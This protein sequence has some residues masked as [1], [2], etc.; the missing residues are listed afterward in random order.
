MVSGYSS[1]QTPVVWSVET[2][3][4]TS[5]E[6]AARLTAEG[7]GDADDDEA[8]D[9]GELPPPPDGGY[10]WVVVFASFMCNLVVD[11]IAYTFG[12]F[13]PE[14]V[15]YFGEGKGTVAW[16]GSLLSGVYLAAGPVVSALCNKYGCRAVCVAGSLI[17]TVAFALSTLSKSVTMMMLTY[18]LI[19][20]IGF[21]MIYLPSVVAVGYYF[22]T[23]RS[24]A[25]GIAVC[26]SGV[27][28]FS[29]APLA[30][31]LLKEFGSWQNANL[32]L[33]GLILNCAVFG[34]LMRPLVYPKTSGE[35]PLLQ[36]MAEEKR[37]QMERG[38]IGGSYFVVQLPDG[39]MEKRLKAPLNI[40]PGVHSSLNLEALARVP[41]V[42]NMPGVPPV[43]T[44]PTITEAKV[45]DDNGE[46]KKAENGS[47]V[48]VQPMSRNVSSPAFSAQAPGL[49][50]NGS[51]P[52]FD[53]QR[54]HSTGE[55]FKPSLAAIKAT[56][57]TS[58]N[59]QHRNAPD[60]D[61]ESGMYNSKLSVSAAREPS[62][63]VRPMSRKDIFYSGSVLNLPQY[64]SQKSLQGY[65]NSVLSLPQSRQAGDLDR[66]EQYDLCPCLTL[67]ESFKSVLSSMLDVSLLRDP[68]F[69][70]IGLSSFFGMAGLYVPFVYIVDAACLN[71][72]DPSQA[73]FLLSIIGITNTFGR[74]ACGAVADLP[75]VD[76]LLLNNICLVIA[77]VSVAVTPFC[78]SYAAYIAVAVA[79]GIA[80]S[81]YISL[82]SIILVDLLG[83]DKLTNAF[84]LLILFR[85]AAAI[86]GSP[87]AG[88]VY[89]MTKNYDASFYMAAGFFL[90]SSAASFAAP[91]F[92]KKQEE[93]QQPMDV[94]TPID[95]DLEE[96][97]DEDPDDT[98]ITMGARIGRP[99][100][101]TRTAASP[102]DPPSPPSPEE[103]P[104]RE[105]LLEDLPDCSEDSD[106]GV[107]DEVEKDLQVLLS[108]GFNDY[109]E[110]AIERV[111][112][113]IPPSP[114]NEEVPSGCSVDQKGKVLNLKKEELLAFIGMNF[115]MGYNTRLAWT[116]HY[117]SASDLN[118]PPIC[119]TMPRDR[120]A[121]I[122]SHLHCNDNAQM[123][124][125]CKDTLYKIRPIVDA[126]NK[127]FQECYHGTREMSV[128]ES[129]IKFKDQRGYIKKIKFSKGKMK[130]MSANFSKYS[131]GE[132]VVLELTEQEW[133]KEK[134]VYFDNF[135]TSVALL[136]K[137]KTENTY[138]CETVRSNRK[139]LPPN[140]LPDS[141][142]KRGESDYRFSNLDIG[143]G[144]ITN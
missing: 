55:R 15:T 120:F 53:R 54:K 69:M 107:S 111:L 123:P 6:E 1:T 26:G 44:L 67:P 16:V 27:G 106:V 57:K 128:D 105:T 142:M 104:Q 71:G 138:A 61:A 77:T 28:T 73:S 96:G 141:K 91:M 52:F 102:S 38:S 134:I 94:L 132:R 121:M 79:F 133:G 34:A 9:Y 82:T 110:E 83:L 11:G 51:V 25:T 93:V 50:K 20:G 64:Q 37:L 59:S 60:G 92:R 75:R 117:P 136:E 115:Y 31:I 119:N 35:K 98:P 129:M 109:F 86:I 46:K 108:R 85:G 42:P 100:A 131:L 40:D 140:T 137:L 99:P 22:E 29:F 124:K 41:T 4:E 144:K 36:R 7:A 56:S 33:A 48:A 32:L 118:N 70:L 103:Q 49:P 76:A 19:G 3:S 2:E 139:G 122:L 74:I 116:D 39:T 5:C 58:M 125:N 135:F 130:K 97:E 45:V 68:A 23:R 62:R 24:L 90:A 143:N 112:A 114:T 21:G 66:Q 87:L 89:D 30:A 101:I 18:G 113:E 12:I 10:G 88:A 47:A 65:R 13:L 72:V 84:G 43:P 14:L 80:I 78:Y 127:K 81:G 8:Y 17:A 95:E 126:V 63:I